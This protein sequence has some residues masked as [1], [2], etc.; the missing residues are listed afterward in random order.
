MN[1]LETPYDLNLGQSKREWKRNVC[2]G[3]IPRHATRWPEAFVVEASEAQT[4]Q[5]CRVVYVSVR[6]PCRPV[7]LAL[8]AS[9][10]LFYFLRVLALLSFFLSPYISKNNLTHHQQII[11]KE[12]SRQF[13]SST[14]MMSHKSTSGSL[15]ARP[16]SQRSQM[17]NSHSQPQSQPARNVER[18]DNIVWNHEIAAYVQIPVRDQKQPSILRHSLFSRQKQSPERESTAGDGERKK[19]FLAALSRGGRE[20]GAKLN[21]APTRQTHPNPKGQSQR[22]VLRLTVPS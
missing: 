20:K 9:D 8:P 14:Q 1:C 15:W 7:A 5:Q 4:Q 6:R 21:Q 18:P 13:L 22:P 11:L 12:K 19:S 2:T 17:S 16:M 10:I 3:F